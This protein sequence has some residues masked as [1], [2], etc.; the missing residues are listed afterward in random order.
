MKQLLTKA[1][2][3]VINIAN[4]CLEADKSNKIVE[5]TAIFTRARK[6]EYHAHQLEKNKIK[7][8]TF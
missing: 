1:C 4:N 8:S 3:A 6:I 5:S 2:I 7:I